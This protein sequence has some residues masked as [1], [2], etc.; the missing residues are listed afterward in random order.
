M[1]DAGYN[2]AIEIAKILTD[3]QETLRRDLNGTGADIPFLEGRIGSQMHDAAALIRHGYDAWAEYVKPRLDWGKMNIRGTTSDFIGPRIEG[4]S[5]ETRKEEFLRSTYN[6]LR[7]GVRKTVSDERN[8]SAEF[9]GPNNLARSL[10]HSRILHFESAKSWLEY[11]KMFGGGSL[12]ESIMQDITMSSKHIGVMRRL[13]TNPENYI[14]N[15]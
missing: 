14:R 12:R 9:K 13:T 1:T 5:V 4:E 3:L 10:S 11:N 15:L 6:A 2:D 8:L 7:S